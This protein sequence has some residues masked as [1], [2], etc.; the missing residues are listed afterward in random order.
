VIPVDIHDSL[1]VATVR[2]SSGGRGID[3]FLIIGGTLTI[4]A[5]VTGRAL[6]KRW[7]AKRNG[8]FD[9]WLRAYERN[10][11]A[12]HHLIM[13]RHRHHGGAVVIDAA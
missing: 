11:R 2:P 6:E 13:V 3:I 10:R 9:D 7:R 5:L 4:E 8:A 1:F 12:I